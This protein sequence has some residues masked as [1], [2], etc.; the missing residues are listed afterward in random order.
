VAPEIVGGSVWLIVGA[1]LT[2]SV[3]NVGRRHVSIGPEYGGSFMGMD[4]DM[5]M[6]SSL[7]ALH[8][9]FATFDIAG[10]IQL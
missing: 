10:A 6:T 8:F 1:G 4:V 9:A 5:V 7:V 2:I 3:P